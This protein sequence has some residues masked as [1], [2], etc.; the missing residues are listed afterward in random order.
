ME[1]Q[2]PSLSVID[3]ELTGVTTWPPS[4]ESSMLPLM[5]AAQATLAISYSIL[6]TMALEQLR[7]MTRLQ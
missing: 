4:E 2:D 6:C 1:A 5:V 3:S 7:L